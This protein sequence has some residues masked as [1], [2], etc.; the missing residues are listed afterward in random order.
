[1][2]EHVRE[3]ADQGTG[4][5]EFLAAGGD[6]PERGTVAAGEV[7]RRG[8]DPAGHLSGWRRWRWRGDG[9]VLAQ[10]GGMPAQGAQAAPVAAVAQLGMQ[11][12]GAAD[13]FVPA[14][15]QPVLVRAEQA[16]P[17][18]AAVGDQLISGRGRGIAADRLALEP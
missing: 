4:R 14:L 11:L 6:L 9:G 15:P 5:V 7:A 3:L 1:M 13:P 8:E 12:P 16:G 10:L 17:G 2:A 18:E